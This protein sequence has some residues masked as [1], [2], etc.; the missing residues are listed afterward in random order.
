MLELFV[1][2]CID[3]S[4]YLTKL[5]DKEI[6]YME[7]ENNHKVGQLSEKIIAESISAL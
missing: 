1:E 2:F 3:E 7:F 6:W 5:T 4:V